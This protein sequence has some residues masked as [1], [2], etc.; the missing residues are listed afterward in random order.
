M[1]PVQ[2][3]PDLSAP[4][5]S[6]DRSG[7]G[8]RFGRQ[9]WTSV[10]LCLFGL[11]VSAYLTGTH[12]FPGAVSLVCADNGAINCAKVTSSPQSALVGIPVASLGLVFFLP[13]LALCLPRAWRSAD[14]RVHLVRQVF[15]VG[16][17]AM[18]LYLVFAELFLIHALCL[19]CSSVH[20]ATFAL[21]VVVTAA[22]PAV[23]AHPDE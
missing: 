22:A 1:T 6:V 12:F 9:T 17:M 16:A 14:R 13:M 18:V 23:L 5:R 7:P 8:S 20:L 3:V 19:W 4:T 2:D 21:F 11:A 15:V 10:V